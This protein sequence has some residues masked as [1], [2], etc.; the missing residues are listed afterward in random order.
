MG[1]TRTLCEAGHRH[2]SKLESAVCQIIHLREKVGELRVI[3]AEDHLKLSAAGIVYIADF[4]CQD[5]RSG[6]FF[7]VEAKGF[8]NDRWPI[9]K[10]LWRFY[11]P[12]RLEIWKGTHNRPFLDETIVPKP[13]STALNA[14][15]TD[16]WGVDVAGL[17][18]FGKSNLNASS[19]TA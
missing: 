11:G 6:E 1:N 18:S 14:A 3:Q 19:C 9:L 17:A 8:E 15:E 16:L 7:W 5:T 12:G 10:K 13:T 2:R 4:K